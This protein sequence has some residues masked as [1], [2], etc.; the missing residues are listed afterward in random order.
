MGWDGMGGEGMG[1]GGRGGGRGWEGGRGWGQGDIGVSGKEKWGSKEVEG[2]MTGI[3]MCTS[4]N[5]AHRFVG[6]FCFQWG[7]LDRDYLYIFGR[8][9]LPTRRWVV[10]FQ[11][12]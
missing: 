8:A 3:N 7:P 5:L 2:P 6:V 11:S 12:S 4:F 10:G 1:G 9:I